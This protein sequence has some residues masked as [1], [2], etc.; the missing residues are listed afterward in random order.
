MKTSA[1]AFLRF[2]LL[3]LFSLLVFVTFVLAQD[4]ECSASIPCKA[5]C[6]SKFGFCGYGKDCELVS[7]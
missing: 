3:T 2:G 4:P 7:L 5:G 6:C 1:S